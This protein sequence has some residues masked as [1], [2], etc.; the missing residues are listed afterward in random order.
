MEIGKWR[1]ELLPALSHATDV[2]SK[3]TS[4]KFSFTCTSIPP[5]ESGLKTALI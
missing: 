2:L 4:F 1:D 5:Q 3:V